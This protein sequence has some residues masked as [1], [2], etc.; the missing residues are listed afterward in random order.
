[1]AISEEVRQII[2]VL[3][4]EG[5]GALAGELL[6]EISLGREIEKEVYVE[7]QSDKADLAETV[8]TR[9]PIEETDQLRTAIDIL[10]ARLVLPVR[11]FVEAE[12]IANEIAGDGQVRIEFIDPEQRAATSPI[13]TRD[14]GDTS[15]ADAL[16]ALLMR[17]P[18][19]IAPPQ[20]DGV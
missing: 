8:I 14:V 4:E 7:N 10:R 13:S 15:V 9:V 18:N 12:K 17:L 20:A 19:M 1:M 5:F 3:E 16:D 2:F 11:A 6:T